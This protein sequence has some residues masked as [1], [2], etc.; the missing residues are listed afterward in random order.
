MYRPLVTKL[1]DKYSNVPGFNTFKEDLIQNTLTEKGGAI[2][3]INAFDGRGA[4]SGYVGR[5][6]PE[7][8][9]ATA[10]KL[11][12]DKFAEDVGAR[13]DVAGQETLQE[14]VERKE[15]EAKEVVAAKEQETRNIIDRAN[16]SPELK[17]KALDA[18]VKTLSTILPQIDIK[19]G[20]NFREKYKL[21]VRNMLYED[22]ST[23]LRSFNDNDYYGYIKLNSEALYDIMP[24]ADL[25]KSQALK[26]L[27]LEQQF[28]KDGKPVRV[29]ESFTG[30]KSYAGN[31]VFKKKP[32][33]QIEK[34]FNSEFAIKHSNHAQRKAFIINT[35]A[36]EIAFDESMQA[37]KDP[38]VQEKLPLTQE[39]EIKEFQQE[40]EMNIQ[41]GRFTK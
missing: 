31:L 29:L 6:L 30:K 17:Q 15:T 40:F 18:S 2:D 10:K 28:D 13:V 37:L 12:P 3:L 35:L 7:R 21:A 8:M 11:F 16:L 5:L 41:R 25:T 22:V 36:K 33:K 27:F 26:S 19:K 1:A 38:K 39:S 24:L 23:E 32:F 20:K 4:L 9:K 34:A 14:E